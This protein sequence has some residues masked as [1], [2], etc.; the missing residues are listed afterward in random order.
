MLQMINLQ[1]AFFLDSLNSSHRRQCEKTGK[2]RCEQR[3]R[4]RI[5]VIPI[6]M[7]MLEDD[8]KCWKMLENIL[9]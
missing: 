3:E 5:E 7:L 6:N 4:S 8:G 2:K 1:N 9:N